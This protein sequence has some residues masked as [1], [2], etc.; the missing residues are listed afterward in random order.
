MIPLAF[1][2]DSR[3]TAWMDNAACTQ[4]DPEIFFP[5]PGD[6]LGEAKAKAVCRACPARSEC[7]SYALVHRI[8][9]GVWGGASEGERR[10][11]RAGQAGDPCDG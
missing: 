11:L 7:L 1:N 6:E 9:Y 3:A 2:G 5:A 8:D 10:A 4:A